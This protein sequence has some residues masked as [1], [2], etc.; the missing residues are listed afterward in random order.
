MS[1][2][3][4]SVSATSDVAFPGLVGDNTAEDSRSLLNEEASAEIPFGMMVAKGSTEGG[5]LKVAANT[6]KLVG[7]VRH[8]HNYSKAPNG[9][10]G[11]TGLKPGVTMMIHTDGPIWVLV[12]ESVAVGDAVRVRGD[13]N[14]STVPGT[15]CKTTSAG[16]TYLLKNA[17]WLKGTVTL[18]DGTTK[19]ALLDIDMANIATATSE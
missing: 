9:E 18:A 15:F 14:S 7:V 16:H 4:T 2:I 6:D 11:T 19:I 8:G 12:D 5:A 3:Q 1:A 10:L 17:R 13:T